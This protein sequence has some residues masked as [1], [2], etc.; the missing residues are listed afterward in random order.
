MSMKLL[1]T[2]VLMLSLISCIDVRRTEQLEEI[3][4]LISEINQSTELL[5][6]TLLDTLEMSVTLGRKTKLNIRQNLNDD[7]LT[8]ER[9]IQ[10]DAYTRNMV[11]FEYI[12]E[13]VPLL[14]ENAEIIENA[15]LTLKSDIENEAGNRSKYDSQIQLEEEKVL[16]LIAKVDSLII[17]KDASL[18]S[19]KELHNKL[20]DFSLKLV[21]KKEDNL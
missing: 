21:E 6:P 20:S 16:K 14:K 12:R 1:L 10:L 5:K 18:T 17:V 11:E 3:D 19:F 7:T 13:Q 2:V 9:A 8:L 4:Q 15:L